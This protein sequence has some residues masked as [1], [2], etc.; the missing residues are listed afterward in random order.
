MEFNK[1]RYY[2]GL[3]VGASTYGITVGDII[4]RKRLTSLSNGYEWMS[5][6][7]KAYWIRQ[8]SN[9][10]LKSHGYP[11]RRG[12]L[13]QHAKDSRKRWKKIMKEY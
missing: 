5:K 1:K 12:S 7:Y 2:P 8:R 9:N 6:E 13:N 4:S 10:W 11:M 3:I